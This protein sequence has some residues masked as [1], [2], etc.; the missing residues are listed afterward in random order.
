MH[1]GAVIIA[2][3][4]STRM[5]DFK[6]LMKLGDMSFSE[7]VITNFQ[8]AGVKDIVMVTGYRNEEVEKALKGTGIAFLLNPDYATTRMFES[9]KI[10]LRYLS[11]RCDFIFFCPVDVP[12]FTMETVKREM[13][14][15]EEADV[16][17]PY[18]HE[19]PGHPILLSKRAVQYILSYQGGHGMRGAYDAFANDHIG[20][21]ARVYVDDA[22]AVM[23]ADTKDDYE[24]LLKLHSARLLRPEIRLRICKEKP[25]FGPGTVTLLRQIQTTGNVREAC[26]RCNMSYSKGWQIIHSCEDELQYNVVEREQG[27]REGGSSRLT[28]HGQELIRLYETLE[29][30]INEYANKRFNEIFLHGEWLKK[31]D[32]GG[33]GGSASDRSA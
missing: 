7:R 33:D 10:G 17:V 26:E 24:N 11:D 2:A 5:K 14:T 15:A 4:M 21:L 16:I 3:G 25:F 8:R 23:D 31:K 12:F 28:K 29:R 20:T 19:R 1:I 27:G 32:S 13:D 18:C 30:D 22:G 9:A 6:Q